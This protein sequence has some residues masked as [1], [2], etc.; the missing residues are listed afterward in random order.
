[1]HTVLLDNQPFAFAVGK[2]VC[3]GRNYAAHAAE[4]NNPV[5]SAPL[6][7]I[8]P[9]DAVV[10]LSPQIRIPQGQGSVHHEVEIAILIGKR[11]KNATE[12]QVKSAVAGVGLAL[13]LTLRDVQDQLKKK[14]HP[15]EA[16]KAFDG[17]SP[18]SE[19]IGLDQ[20]SDINNIA[21]CLTRNGQIQQQGNSQ[22][23]LFPILPLI[24]HMSTVFT[25]NPGDV[26]LT[27]TPAGVGELKL[28]DQLR[29]TLGSDLVV[30][31]EV[32]KQA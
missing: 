8:K 30:N 11:L 1:M 23:M 22:D 18:V 27:G 4:L 20:V 13:D 10:P 24:A 7:F 5:P 32:S 31:T 6:L 3:V 2:C 16:A 14:G 26:I 15:W 25:L 12:T 21:F 28:G 19:F 29:L 17:A 9:A